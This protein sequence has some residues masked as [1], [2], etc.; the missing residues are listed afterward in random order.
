MSDK[1]TAVVTGGAG[2]LGSHL[3]DR[4]ITIGALNFAMMTPIKVICFI[5]AHKILGPPLIL[6]MM[7][8]FHNW[9]TEAFV[10]LRF[11]RQLRDA[12]AA[13]VSRLP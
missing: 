4:L 5:N 2:F 11:T 10:Y 12:L 13:Q 9:S 1:R 8:W 7:Y 6:G 3:A